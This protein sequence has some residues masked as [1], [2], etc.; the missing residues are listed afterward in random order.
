MYPFSSSFLLPCKLKAAG[1]GHSIQTRS[2]IYAAEGNTPAAAVLFGKYSTSLPNGSE[3]CRNVI[4]VH[5][6]TNQQ[7]QCSL[8]IVLFLKHVFM[9]CIHFNSEHTHS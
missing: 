2:A 3:W 4:V 8:F 1:S 7:Q 6:K 9:T 5:E